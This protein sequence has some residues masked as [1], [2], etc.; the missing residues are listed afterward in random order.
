MPTLYLRISAGNMPYLDALATGAGTSKSQAV[1]LI[2][3]AARERGWTIAP[4]APR[5]TGPGPDMDTAAGSD[6]SSAQ[7]G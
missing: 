6:H 7:E 1:D 2:I 5:I 3:T 4:G